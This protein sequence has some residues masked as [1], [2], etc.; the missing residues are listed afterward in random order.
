MS[1]A[2]FVYLVEFLFVGLL[3]LLALVGFSTGFRR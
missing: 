2:Q 1:E 3:L